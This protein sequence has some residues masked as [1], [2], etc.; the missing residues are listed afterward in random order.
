MPYVRRE[1]EIANQKKLREIEKKFKQTSSSKPAADALRVL[2]QEEPQIAQ[3]MVQASSD[4]ID[5][6]IDQQK[7]HKCYQL[8]P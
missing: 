3:D 1:Q 4:V 2:E 5:K 7:E 6:L 8:L